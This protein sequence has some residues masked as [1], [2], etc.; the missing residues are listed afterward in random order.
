MYVERWSISM[1][2]TPFYI[3]CYSLWCSPPLGNI[4]H[5]RATVTGRNP[6]S[7]LITTTA[8]VFYNLIYTFILMW[9]VYILCMH[10]HSFH[11]FMYLKHIYLYICF[12]NT[13]FWDLPIRM[14]HLMKV[15]PGSWHYMFPQVALAIGL[16]FLL[17]VF[18]YRGGG[19]IPFH[20]GWSY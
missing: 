17:H 19:L 15:D 18:K 13:W 16:G 6:A 7:Q 3:R 9:Y 11:A 2:N 4:N 10:I 14:D 1:K 12:V 8:V 5:R 20:A